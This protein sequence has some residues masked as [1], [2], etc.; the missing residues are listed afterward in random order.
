MY[1]SMIKMI[2]GQI[3][4]EIE[5]DLMVKVSQ[6]VGYEVDKDE[7][8]KA[9]QYDRNQYEKGYKDGIHADKWISTNDKLP[10]IGQPVLIYYPY[11]T[12]LEVQAARLDYDKLTFDICGE[13][14]ASVNKVTHW[15]PLPQMPREAIIITEEN[16]P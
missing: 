15:Q 12:G 4:S 14:N 11:W 9:L 3:Q 8:I 1:E 2:A 10:E 6:T 7:L 13:F 5:N 16:L